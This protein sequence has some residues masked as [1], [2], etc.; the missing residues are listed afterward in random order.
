MNP[1]QGFG[2]KVITP[3]FLTAIDT[4]TQTFAAIDTPQVMTL[5]TIQESNKITS[6]GNGEFEFTEDGVYKL[7]IFPIIT[8][9]TGTVISHFLWLQQDVGS[10]FVDLA[11]S[12]S[13]TALVGSGSDTRTLTFVAIIRCNKG[14]KIR[15]MN[16][17]TS[18]NITLV[19]KNPPAG[20]G[21]R[22]PSIIMSID[23]V[24]GVI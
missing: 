13:E 11:D 24:I 3:T 5:N 4:T 2:A 1:P 10:G 9:T 12:N 19:T 16:S 22:I 20:N 8:K 18:T 21:P 7:V 15:F 17:V 23:K 6:L 14:D